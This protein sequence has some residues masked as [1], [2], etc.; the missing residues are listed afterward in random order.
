MCYNQ[1]SSFIIYIFVLAAAIKMF[2]MGG[3]HNYYGAML[4]VYGSVQLAEFLIWSGMRYRVKNL[5]YFGSLLVGLIISI[6]PLLLALSAKETKSI[7]QGTETLQNVNYGMI[8]IYTAILFFICIYNISNSDI[9]SKVE[10]SSCR[11][12][13]SILNG[14][15]VLLAFATILYL[16]SSI[17]VLYTTE[18]YDILGIFVGSFVASVIYTRIVGKSYSI[19]SL[20]CFMAILAAIVSGFFK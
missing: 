4:L 14:P 13:W 6:Q 9:L 12:Y 20:W 1:E 8:A 17:I 2:L 3:R 19:G 7:T 15:F 5:N 11:L 18:S 10:K 16:V